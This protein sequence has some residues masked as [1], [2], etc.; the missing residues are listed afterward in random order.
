MKLT[1][2]ALCATAVSVVALPGCGA[3]HRSCCDKPAATATA[4]EIEPFRRIDA[5]S[6]DSKRQGAAPIYI[7]DNNSPERYAKGH[8]PGAVSMAKD[9]VKADALPPNKD[10]MLVFYCGSPQCMAC[11]AAAKAAIALGYTN[12]FIMPDGIK[13][14]EELNLPVEKVAQGRTSP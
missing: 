12:V 5:K 4:A 11:H 1:T 6:L 8:V 13:G 14:W 2:L 7:Y 3:M 9:A 10:A